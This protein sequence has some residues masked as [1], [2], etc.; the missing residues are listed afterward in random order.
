[1]ARL[2]VSISMTPRRLSYEEASTKDLDVVSGILRS[3]SH[4]SQIPDFCH[5]EVSITSVGFLSIC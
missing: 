5:G 1:M 4:G 2:P 3:L